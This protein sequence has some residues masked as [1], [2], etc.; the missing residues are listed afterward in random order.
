MESSV[1]AQTEQTAFAGVITCAF[2][3]LL[4]ILSV[5]LANSLV[6]Y[7]DFFNSSL[8]C[9]SI[10]LSW[11][12]LRV[13]RKENK[14]VFNYGLGKIENLSS[15]FIGLFM[16]LSI[17][18]MAFLVVNRLL[19]L[20]PIRGAG[21]WMGIVCTLVFGSLNGR[22]WVKSLRHQKEDPSPIVNAQCRLFAI[23]T[24]ANGCMFL[25]FILSV[26]LAYR[27]VLYLDPLASCITVGFMIQSAWNLIRHSIHD[28]LDRSLD[29]PLQMMITRQL[30]K[31]YDAYTALD[32]VRSRYSGQMV[33]IEI[34][35]GFDPHQPL[36]EIQAVTDSMKQAL[37]QEIPH[38]QVLIIPRV[39]AR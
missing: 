8:Q 2:G 27:W 32:E 23:K 18:I 5:V 4:N 17:L 14:A 20:V 35:L 39:A 19:H 16:L 22:L 28:L 1:R 10:T 29:E 6:L 26:T 3:L 7:A 24:L 21:V 34:I 33:F 9:A 36:G 15:L 30:A 13:L 38:S 12:T 37:E 31:H 25:T 11:L